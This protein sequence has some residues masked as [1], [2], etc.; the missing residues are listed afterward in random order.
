MRLLYFSTDQFFLSLIRLTERAVQPSSD[1][2]GNVEK[3]VKKK[4]S[5]PN[6]LGLKN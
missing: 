3:E 4:I 5:N 6:T 2:H 1:L